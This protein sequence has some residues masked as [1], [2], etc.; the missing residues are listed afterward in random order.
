M[1][2]SLRRSPRRGAVL[3]VV[4][5]VLAILSL[6]ATSFATLQ[7]TERQV[8]R[9][10]LDTV[11]A[12]LLAQ[13]GVQDALERLTASAESG[14]L[15]DRSMLYWGDNVS[16]T[17]APDA[18]TPL[19]RA[20][21]PS[22]AWED[23]KIQDPSDAQTRPMSFRIDGQDLGVSGLTS[24]GAY[25][26]R[27]ADCNSMIHVND[28]L[29]GGPDGLISKN[30]RRVLN[31]LGELLSVRAAGDRVLE[32]RPAAGY[33]LKRELETALGS[34]DYAKLHP[35]L[36]PAAWVDRSVALPVPISREVLAAYP[37]KYNEKLGIFR[38]GRSFRADGRPLEKSPLL[39]A[40]DFAAPAGTEHA[41]MALD[42]L[43]AQVI[44]IG[45][46]A[47]VNVNLAAREVL[48]ALIAD[49]RGVFL[50][51]RRKQNP[52]GNMYTFLQHPTYDNDPAGRLGDEYG[53]LY[54]TPPFLLP[55][56]T[57]SAEGV[58]A[59]KV[60]DEII[61]CRLKGTSPGCPGLDY[62]ALWYGGPFRSW[63]QFAAFCDG[64]ADGGLLKDERKIFFDYQTSGAFSSAETGPDILVPSASQAR[65]AA[66][67][68]ADVLKANF[69][70]NLCLN[71]TN[72]DANLFTAV[73]KTDLIVNS[74]EFCFTSMGLFD[75]ESE[76]RVLLPLNGPDHRISRQATTAALSK[77]A[78]VVKVFDVHRETS[79]A[80]FRAGTILDKKAVIGPEPEANASRCRWGGWMQ[81]ATTGGE[82]RHQG[83]ELGDTMHGHFS[84]GHDL[85]F[86]AGGAPA[87]LRPTAGDYRNNPDRTEKQPGP[88]GPEKHDLA[89]SRRTEEPAAA[90]EAAA[91]G[92]L[93]IDGAYVERDAA[94]MYANGEQIFDLAG[95]VAYWIKP[96]FHPEMTGKPRT[97]FSLDRQITAMNSAGKS[98]NF[99]LILGH[100]FFASH[101]AP[102]GSASPNEDL[103][104]VY[105]RSP[106]RP[107][108][109]AA[110]YSTYGKWGGGVGTVSR[111]LHHGAHA[112]TDRADQ[113]RA[114]TW[115]HVA[116]HWDMKRHRTELV[117]N[118][119]PVPAALNTIK[120]HPDDSN[121]IEDFVDIPLRFGEPSR[122][123]SVGR[124][125]RNWTA[126]AT[127]DELY[128][129][130]G[131]ALDRAETLYSRGRFHVPR[132]GKEA[133]FTSAPLALGRNQRR[134]PG[135]GTMTAG[136]GA[137]RIL[138]AA[139]T[140]YPEWTDEH[141]APKAWDVGFQSDDKRGDD[142]DAEVEMRMV[143]NGKETGAPLSD[144][145]GASAEA[146]FVGPGD[147]AQYRLLWRLRRAG[148]DSALLG[149]PV[150]DDVTIYYSEGARFLVYYLDGGMP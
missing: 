77:I 106:W 29:E 86:H 47:P 49:L 141:G 62:A 23:E 144:D 90:L 125:S 26:L 103:P 35:F 8:S 72:P 143:L 135:G 20:R 52:G 122:T 81:L 60:A 40:P 41:V 45:A 31:N 55:G 91:P 108:S 42:E 95:T 94:L 93:R 10:Y 34:P 61:A 46:R 101:D 104:P 120:V 25:R 5:G 102:A 131:N 27:V 17:G 58:D 66:R 4:L 134:L 39:F 117:I 119:R 65:Y 1:K 73:D 53:F 126:D 138:A 75:I 112:D 115:T 7:I 3:I 148:L 83:A 123:T 97:F 79:Q 98:Q 118:G 140:W 78:C 80:D 127:L 74:T 150:V 139:W 13:S 68:M 2:I 84:T 89:R 24:D 64:L 12:K 88:Y 19:D 109:M 28:G 110:G 57:T 114:Q 105:W 100:W 128:V 67:A 16:E 129:W 15:Q 149:T 36:T 113:I 33:R 37:V 6:L 38:Y 137:F 21:N 121:R 146:L 48:T 70:P 18:R 92:D 99:P 145:G 63:R 82:G 56:R 87:P 71:E 111:S 136:P 50:V 22:F 14:R 96:S 147:S 76:G 142:L 11:R 130:K 124:Y 132:E 133:V 69:N 54:A 59:S 43:N 44:E 51:G 116:F 85:H 32:A 9:N 107:V 30:L